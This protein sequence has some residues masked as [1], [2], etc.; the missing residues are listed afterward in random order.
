MSFF[1][2]CRGR[3]G[4]GEIL[5]PICGAF[6]WELTICIRASAKLKVVNLV[7]LPLECREMVLLF[8]FFFLTAIILLEKDN[9]WGD[10]PFEVAGRVEASDVPFALQGG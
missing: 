8:G 6:A 2:C 9:G 1:V 5:K 10:F 4:A 3:G 7:F